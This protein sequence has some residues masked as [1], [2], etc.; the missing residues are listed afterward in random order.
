MYGVSPL[1]NTFTPFILPNTV[2]FTTTDN[3]GCIVAGF[4]ARTP[5]GSA[6][7]WKSFG[8]VVWTIRMYDHLG[9]TVRIV[10]G[11][12][13]QHVHFYLR[14]VNYGLVPAFATAPLKLQSVGY[15]ACEC[16]AHKVYDAKQGDSAHSA[17]CPWAK[18]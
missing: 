7:Y 13:D 12:P 10:G 15:D 6:S 2:Q 16:G 17:W 5:Y 8:G 11:V 9:T 18:K 4:T 1:H 3:A 14:D